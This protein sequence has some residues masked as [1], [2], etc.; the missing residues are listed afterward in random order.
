VLKVHGFDA[1]NPM[2]ISEMSQILSVAPNRTNQSVNTDLLYGYAENV[3][4]VKKA[5]EKRETEDP[6][7]K[8]TETKKAEPE[9]KKAEV[10]P[11]QKKEQSPQLQED[12]VTKVTEEQPAVETVPFGTVKKVTVKDEVKDEEGFGIK[13]ALIYSIAGLVLIIIAGLVMFFRAKKD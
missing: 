11:E 10:V 13:D 12:T 7:K 8:V 4:V 2:V 9:T 5:E 6:A 3:V 1:D